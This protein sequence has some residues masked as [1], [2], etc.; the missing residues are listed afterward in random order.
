MKLKGFIVIALLLFFV[1]SNPSGAASAARMLGTAITAT[2]NGFGAMFTA[3]GR[4]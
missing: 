2:A 4:G 3:L 1:A